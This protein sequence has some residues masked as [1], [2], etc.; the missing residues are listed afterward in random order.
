MEKD[1]AARPANA[2]EVISRLLAIGET[3]DTEEPAQ[4]VDR[5]TVMADDP[6][7]RV[8]E[9][10][11][12]VAETRRQAGEHEGPDLGGG[13]QCGQR[14]SSGRVCRTAFQS[15]SRLARGLTTTSK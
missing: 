10:R 8:G 5:Q 15:L 3:L 14:S 9:T 11:H 6:V 13:G 7:A 2:A 1:R 4:E 12:D